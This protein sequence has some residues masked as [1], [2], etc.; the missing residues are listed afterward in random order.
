MIISGVL[1]ETQRHRS[2]RPPQPSLTCSVAKVQEAAQRLF[3]MACVP[4]CGVSSHRRPFLH[5]VSIVRLIGTD[6]KN[7][8]FTF[9]TH[10]L[11][12]DDSI[13]KDSP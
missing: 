12:I 3:G 8:G 9:G 4:R 5:L 10:F 11:G 2:E 1:I 6:S 13:E 7:V